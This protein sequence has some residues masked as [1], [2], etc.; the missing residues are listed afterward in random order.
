MSVYVSVYVF[1][2]VHVEAQR[3]L[4]CPFF[5]SLLTLLLRQGHS[6]NLLLTDS[7]RPTSLSANLMDPPVSASP[8]LGLHDAVPGFYMGAEDPNSGP[9][10][11]T[12]NTLPVELA[13]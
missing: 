2:Y 13:P 4:S 11:C 12:A 7:A 3:M 1:A 10:A 5:N 9:S 8:V 6:L